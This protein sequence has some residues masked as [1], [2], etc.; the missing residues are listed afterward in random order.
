MTAIQAGPTG[1]IESFRQNIEEAL[2]LTYQWIPQ[3]PKFIYDNLKSFITTLQ[4]M[5]AEVIE[6][7][8]KRIEVISKRI[9]LL[10]PAMADFF[11]EL[12]KFISKISIKTLK[13]MQKVFISIAEHSIEIVQT[14]LGMILGTGLA[15]VDISHQ[16][17]QSALKNSIGVI[18]PALPPF[19]RS[20]LT[21]G[22]VGL[23]SYYS[24]SLLRKAAKFASETSKKPL[25]KGG[26]LLALLTMGLNLLGALI[27]LSPEHILPPMTAVQFNM[28][29]LPVI[30]MLPFSIY[31]FKRGFIEQDT[32]RDQF[33]AKR[34]ELKISP[35][36]KKNTNAKVT[37]E[38]S[39][40]PGY[41][42][43]RASKKSAPA[44]VKA[45]SLK[46]KARNKA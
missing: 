8:S 37:P 34:A 42:K 25:T 9:A 13:E 1:S 21:V 45:A 12:M 36:Q 15:I 10:L 29:M 28:A 4:L 3:A 22:V 19:L 7:I 5:F 14:T 44:K 23:G 27:I 16:L 30:A 33:E 39:I 31:A 41:D 24:L 2:W 17:I 46:R 38:K 6:A 32:R 43:K 18:L 35:D 11:A 26:E 40:T 20:A